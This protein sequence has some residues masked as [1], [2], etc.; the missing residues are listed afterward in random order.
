M[1]KKAIECPGWLARVWW[2]KSSRASCSLSL[3][4]SHTHKPRPPLTPCNS[5]MLSQG[6]TDVEGS[7]IL[8]PGDDTSSSHT[9]A[10]STTAV[11]SDQANVDVAVVKSNLQKELQALASPNKSFENWARTFR[12]VPE[13]YYSPSTEKDIVQVHYS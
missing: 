4:L 8:V 9:M 2:Q 7:F 6:Q 12:C 13:Q 3:S 11:A 5:L 1:K 10:S